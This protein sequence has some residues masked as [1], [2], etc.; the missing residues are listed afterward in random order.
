[1]NN[2]FDTVSA[3]GHYSASIGNMTSARAPA[4][5]TTVVML[6]TFSSSEDSNMHSNVFMALP[7]RGEMRHL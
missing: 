3:R 1:M 4:K 2:V 7:T 6:I 5:R